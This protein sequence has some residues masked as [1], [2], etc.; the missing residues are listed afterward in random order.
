MY[1]CYERIGGKWSAAIMSWNQDAKARKYVHRVSGFRRKSQAR[2]A[3][4]LEH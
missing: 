3:L 4:Q 2:R 1:I